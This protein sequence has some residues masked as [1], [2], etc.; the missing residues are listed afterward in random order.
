MNDG[1]ECASSESSPKTAGRPATGNSPIA[2]LRPKC[3]AVVGNSP[4]SEGNTPEFKGDDPIAAAIP[5]RVNGA[6][7]IP[8]SANGGQSQLIE[9]VEACI[10]LYRTFVLGP[11]LSHWCHRATDNLTA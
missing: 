6:G 4:E 5:N 10:S 11:P 9:F 1:A 2:K 7:I 3:G 8:N